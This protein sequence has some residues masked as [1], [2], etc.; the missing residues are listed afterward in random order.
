MKRIFYPL[1]LLLLVLPLAGSAQAYDPFPGTTHVYGFEIFGGDS[2]HHV[3]RVDSVQ[4]QNGDTVTY[5]NRV[6][7]RTWAFYNGWWV[8]RDNLFGAQV[9]RTPSGRVEFVRSNQDTLRLE[10]AVPVGNSWP[11]G[12]GNTAVLASR[13]LASF[14][15]VSDTVLT[16][17]VG[18][19]EI[20]LS[21]SHGLLTGIE[22]VKLDSTVGPL[23]RISLVGIEEFSLG[24]SVPR[25]EEYVDFPIGSEFQFRRLENF[26]LFSADKE[27]IENV[28]ITGK[29]FQPG[30][31][32]DYTTI[33]ERGGVLNAPPQ[34]DTFYFPPG[35]SALS[36]TPTQPFDYSLSTFTLDSTSITTF[37]KIRSDGRREYGAHSKWPLFFDPID[38]GIYYVFETS[39]EQYFTTGLGRTRIWYSDETGND[40]TFMTCYDVVTASAGI[41][42]DISDFI[43]GIE[44]QLDLDEWVEWGPNP[45]QE[46]IR[47]EA[48]RE[49]QLEVRNALGQKVS[50]EMKL[51]P[52]T[53]E[54]LELGPLPA[55]SYWLVFRTPNGQYGAQRMIH[56]D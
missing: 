32:M 7:H 2:A 38:S 36:Y 12:D 42:R 18:A 51:Q 56:V 6:V 55:G 16:Y 41:C 19:D 27:T 54:V 13:G 17:Q 48:K 11:F 47:V 26:N 28:T 45:S 53:P 22:M 25:W 52:F 50:G 29:T 35:P 1:L 37:I 33:R 10:T 43:V 21:R 23:S 15:G 3:V 14:L 4:I 39:E 49:M 44:E 46:R 20:Q 8:N 40:N 34:P 5:M 9:R 31:S 24:D 30:I